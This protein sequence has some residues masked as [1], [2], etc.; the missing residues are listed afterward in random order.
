M[1]ISTATL[2]PLVSA[3][4]AAIASI[5]ARVLL[6]GI[7]T[8]KIL[9]VNFFIMAATLLVLSPL[10]YKFIVSWQSVGLVVLIA[11]IDTLANYFYFKTFEQTEASVAVPILSL[12][13]IVTFLFSGII[14]HEHPRFITILASLA[15]IALIV[16]ISTDWKRWRMF[17]SATLYPALASAFLF[18][19][20]AIPSKYL[21]S[22][23][24]ATNAPT[25]YMI[26]AALIALFSILTFRES[27]QT[28]DLKTYR[29]I[30]TRGLFVIGQWV[31]L[32][33]ALTLGSTGV[34][35]TL[36]N[37]TPVFVL[38]LSV[39][40][41]KEKVNWKKILAVLAILAISLT[42]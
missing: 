24:H 36:G 18:G 14:L 31:L 20:S 7:P 11:A 19:I 22:T 8:K 6:K 1:L 34:A 35:V 2:I 4:L 37:I 10:F 16:V 17:S 39:F 25:L 32:Y 40:L 26:R 33:Y 27:W 42:I 41:L 5:L 3:L 9:A 30:F 13:P 29:F 21:L 38:L 23:L 28:L 12:A 15:I